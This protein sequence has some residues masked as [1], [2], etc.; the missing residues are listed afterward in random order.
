M[1]HALNG[2][3]ISPVDVS[4]SQIFLYDSPQGTSNPYFYL[5][6]KHYMPIKIMLLEV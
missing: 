6:R 4:Q 1:K 3:L 5:H 2:Q